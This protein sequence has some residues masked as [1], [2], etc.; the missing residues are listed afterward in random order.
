MIL[1]NLQ[2]INGIDLGWTSNTTLNSW[3]GVSTSDD[4]VITLNVEDIGLTCIPDSMGYLNRLIR[5]SLSE[6]NITKIPD[7]IGNLNNL[8][9]LD[10]KIY[11]I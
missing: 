6:N 9:T 5:L 1:L 2:I 10:L 3:H 8:I 4:R 11:L 7:S